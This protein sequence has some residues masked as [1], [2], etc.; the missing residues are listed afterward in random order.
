MFSRVEKNINFSVVASAELILGTTV[1]KTAF[2]FLKRD[3]NLRI[4][5]ESL[6]NFVSRRTI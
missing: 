5:N 6:G 1:K 4:R 3:N 2:D